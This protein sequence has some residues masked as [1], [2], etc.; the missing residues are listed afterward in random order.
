ME[1]NKNKNIKMFYLLFTSLFFFIIFFYNLFY[2]RN[3]Y[4]EIIILLLF[5]STSYYAYLIKLNNKTLNEI[6]EIIIFPIFFVLLIY[7]N[8]IGHFNDINNF[9]QTINS[10]LGY[11]LSFFVISIYKFIMNK[12]HLFLSS[13]FLFSFSLID[14]I[15]RLTYTNEYDFKF[16]F[17]PLLSYGNY[18]SV[19]KFNITFSIIIFIITII[20]NKECF[21]SLKY[22]SLLSIFYY[23]YKLIIIN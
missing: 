12:N 23:L 2:I 1:S 18:Y 17:Y 5:L 8:K 4:F 22:I 13:S 6:K 20:K 11:Y 16:L 19:I 3:N 7:I 9:T 10:Y 15:Y 14:A 21:K